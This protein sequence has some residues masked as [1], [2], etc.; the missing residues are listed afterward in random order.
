MSATRQLNRFETPVQPPPAL[1]VGIRE[2]TQTVRA[3]ALPTRTRTVAALVAVPCVTAA[4]LAIASQVVYRHQAVGLDVEA[5]AAGHMLV[6]LCSLAAVAIGATFV[7]LRRSRDTSDVVRLIVAAS[8]VV[9]LY[10]VLTLVSPLHA[11]AAP[12]FGVD[13]SPW[14]A[15][16]LV[17]AG[18][19]G[20][21][22]LAAFTAALRRAVPSASGLRGA[23]LGAAAGAWAGLTVFI[24]CPSGELSHLV[25]GHVL[26]VLALTLAGLFAIP[27]VLRP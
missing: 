8:V 12:P 1:Y 16:C 14:G 26:P 25:I 10:A 2:R 19:V 7:A 21:L 9:P 18:V 13:I 22:T 24:F 4:A 20:G 17:L 6:V 11:H 23:A 3:A 5:G 15:R 27:R